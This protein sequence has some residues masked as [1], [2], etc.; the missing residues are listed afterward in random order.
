[1]ERPTFEAMLDVDLV[2]KT[3]DYEEVGRAAHTARDLRSSP[4]DL[5]GQS[6][7]DQIALELDPGSY[8]LAIRIQDRGSGDV[9]IFRIETVV[10]SF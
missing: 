8:R 1:M 5:A 7:L 9:G 4:E 10:R 3:P 6:V 2:A